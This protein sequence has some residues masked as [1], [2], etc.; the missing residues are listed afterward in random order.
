MNHHAKTLGSPRAGYFQFCRIGK[1]FWAITAVMLLVLF[2]GCQNENGQQHLGSIAGI[3]K[4]SDPD[5]GTGNAGILVYLAGTAYQAR[6]DQ[7]GRYR[8]DGIPPGTYDLIAQKDGYQGQVIEGLTLSSGNAAQPLQPAEAMLPRQA[9]AANNNTSSTLGSIQGR[10]YLEGMPDENGGVRVEVDGTAFVTVSSN[11]GQ[12]RIMN[13]EPGTYHLSFYRDGFLPY[14]EVEAVDVTSG[15]VAQVKDV[16][17]Q[18]MQPGDPVSAGAVAEQVAAKAV[19]PSAANEPAPGPNDKRSI[20]GVVEVTDS[21]GRLVSDYSNVTVAI[22]GTAQVAEINDQGQFRF[23]N[24]T[25][26]VYT[27]IGT[28]PEGPIVQIPV[29]LENQRSASVSVK[30]IQGSQNATAGG[31]TVR[32]KIILVDLDDKPVGDSSGVRVAVNG[33]QAMA[34]TDAEGNYS[35]ADV[36]PGTYTISATKDG[37]KPGQASGV[38]V[39][40]AAPVEAAEIRMMIDVARPRV[41]STNP[42]NRARDV[43]VAFNLPILI[44]FSDKM[45]PASIQKAISLT[46]NTPYNIQIG[47]GAG[48]GADDDTAVILLSNE[49]AASPIQFGANYRVTVA[50]TAANMAG[51]SMGQP[52]TFTFST[53]KPGIIGTVPQNNAQGV[54]VDQTQNP[55]L[56]SFNTRLDPKTINSRNIRVKP[57][58]GVSVATTYNDNDQNGWTTVRVATRWQADTAYTITITRRVK[59]YNGQVLGNTPY[60]LKFRTQSMDIMSVPI[61]TTR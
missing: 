32:G 38:E 60:T 31:G 51:V 9:V 16:A 21:A 35:M 43:E 44:K 2:G 55:V 30:L 12:Y 7:Q 57:D 5:P 50:G 26:G 10:V 49:S 56:I 20:V 18:L 14:K 47:K 6:T 40:D 17:L 4:L 45:D 24:L 8:I 41:I 19:A 11:D 61:L 54:Y 59:A 42:A 33:T 46:P 22:N 29:D 36:P 3:A 15:S 58:P 34:T 53:A 52:Y 27:L 37:Y 28:M 39:T 48:A 1:A 23:D 25:S 13:V